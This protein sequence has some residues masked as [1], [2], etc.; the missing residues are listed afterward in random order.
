MKMTKL[1]M[2][3]LLAGAVFF[4]FSQET[5]TGTIETDLT[6][7]IGGDYILQNTFTV[8]SGV[9]LT[10]PEGVSIVADGDSKID[11]YGEVQINGTEIDSVTISANGENI[12]WSGITIYGSDNCSFN[13]VDISDVRG[14]GAIRVIQFGDDF[15]N[16]FV[17]DISFLPSSSSAVSFIV[18]EPG[19]VNCCLMFFP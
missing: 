4:C 19:F 5:L 3:L 18:Y 8:L 12:F 16:N 2:T 17:V 11:I 14:L 1:L 7:D 9:T 15:T 13:Y 6:L 10:I